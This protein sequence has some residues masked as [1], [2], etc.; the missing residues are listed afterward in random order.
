MAQNRRSFLKT[1]GIATAV[2]SA[3]PFALSMHDGLPGGATPALAANPR[4][5]TA[6]K[7]A[8]ELDGKSVG[9]LDAY[10]GGFPYAD[11]IEERGPGSGVIARKH[12]GNPKYGEITMRVTLGMDQVLWDWIAAMLAGNSLRK[13]GSIILLDRDNVARRRLDFLNALIT[14]VGFPA[15]DGA[16]KEPAFLTIVFSPE[17]TTYKT[18]SGKYPPSSGKQKQ[19]LCSNFRLKLGDLPCSRVSKID[20]FTI[21]QSVTESPVGATRDYEREPAAIEI[22]N[23][24]VTLAD[25]D[26]DAWF[27]FFEEFV[28]KGN[29]GQEREIIGVLDCLAPD[30]RTVLASV[31]FSQVGIFKCAPE[32][33]EPNLDNTQ[34]IVAELY[35][36]QMA[37]A[38]GA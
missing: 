6:G 20:A 23:L 13:S 31:S 12:I 2:A 3:A 36:E 30:G 28:L 1:A 22:P 18:A 14:E 25:V 33:T 4:S 34:R 26:A 29:N 38:V 24:A 27:K 9:I 11:V 32:L 15:L 8:L 19:W 16:S 17:R 35:V 5:F 21:K 37:F 7:F 10:G